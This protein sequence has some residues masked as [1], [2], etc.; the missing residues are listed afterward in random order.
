MCV[1]Y[2][3]RSKLITGLQ[4]APWL[5]SASRSPYRL[6]AHRKTPFSSAGIYFFMGSWFQI[7]RH[8]A[9]VSAN[10]C[11]LIEPVD[12]W[13]THLCCGLEPLLWFMYLCCG[14]CTSVLVYVPLLGFMYLCCGLEILL[15]F[16]YLCYGLCTS[17]VV[18]VPLLWFRTSVMVYVPLLWFMYL[19]C[20]LCTSVVVYVPLVGLMYLW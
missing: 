3:L 7:A 11:H 19:C 6:T 12:L 4:L 17:V 20:G 5:R 14:L 15:G 8:E 1:C 13:L 9:T 10:G 18:Y 16:M 2:R